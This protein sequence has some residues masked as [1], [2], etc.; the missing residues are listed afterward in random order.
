MDQ[1][2]PHQATSS[3]PFEVT[4]RMVMMIAVPMTLAA[5][6][7]PLLGLVDMGV[8]G[9]LG[10]AELIGGLAIG[11]LVFDFLLSVFSFLRSGTTGLV[12][13]AMG[14]GDE[15]EEQAIFW[16]AILV[17]IAAGVLMILC[18]PLI[19][20]AATQFMHPT[21]ATVD[22]MSTYVAIRIF[23]AP[24]ALIN[25][26]I[27]GLL[28]GRGRGTAALALQILLN[29]I[30]IVL[31][32]ILGL[33][34]GW[35]V[36]GVAWATVT[37]EVVAALLGLT[38]VIRHFAHDASL[39]PKAERIFQRAGL[40]RMFAINRDIMIR[41]ILLLTAFAFFT[42]V[43][44]EMGPV[45]LAA[46][47]VLMNFF[48][49]AGFFLDGM[50]AAVEQ[51]VGRSIGANHRPA[52]VRGAQL[53]FVWG[54]CMSVVVGLLLLVFGDALIGL[55]S[56]AEDVHAEAVRYLPWAALT[57]LSGLLAFHMDGV[58]I[59]ATWSRD[60]RNMMFLSLALFLAVLYAA[61]P[62]IGNHGLWLALNL[63]LSIRGITLLALLPRRFHS[64]FPARA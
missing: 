29:G 24:F 8:I 40:V 12:A 56:K 1:S 58:Y 9:Q 10:Q 51:I 62:L 50:S 27:L 11:A 41:S 3:R 45:T 37:G 53:T 38:L 18:A 17:A 64:Q 42:R 25:Y 36:A 6:T 19:I 28:L 43:G 5:V 61:K 22:A 4:H 26:S 63:F 32:I 13:Q 57:A 52:F 48:L 34:L 39:R 20:A 54:L 59:G 60:M 47:S 21:E 14:A 44:T 46:N 35:G 49:V 33:E 30:N 55:L 31:C 23:S 15:V 7:T 16:R 2:L